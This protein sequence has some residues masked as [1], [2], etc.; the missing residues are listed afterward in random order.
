MCDSIFQTTHT[1]GQNDYSYAHL[2]LGTE[3]SKFTAFLKPPENE[4]PN[5]NFIK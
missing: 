5:K 3:N 4:C 2:S 1:H